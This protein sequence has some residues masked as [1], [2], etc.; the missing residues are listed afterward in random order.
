MLGVPPP[1]ILVTAHHSH[2]HRG[3]QSHRGAHAE[4]AAEAAQEGAQGHDAVAELVPEGVLDLP[5]RRAREPRGGRRGTA[6]LVPPVRVRKRLEAR[7]EGGGRQDVLVGKEG[8]GCVGDPGGTQDSG[9]LT[10]RSQ[11]I[12]VF[13]ANPNQRDDKQSLGECDC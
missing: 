3:H 10:A 11:P 7:K 8:G 9:R 12:A 6:Q 1:L 13:V 5:G 2:R 4:G